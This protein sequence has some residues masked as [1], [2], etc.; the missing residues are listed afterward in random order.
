MYTKGE[1]LLIQETKISEENFTVLLNAA[2]EEKLII[3]TLIKQVLTEESDKLVIISYSY[4]PAILDA[5]IRNLIS[6]SGS[7]KETMMQKIQ[8][9][10]PTQ[11]T[12]EHILDLVKS[13][14][15][16][17]CTVLLIGAERLDELYGQEAIIR[18]TFPEISIQLFTPSQ[19]KFNNTIE[20]LTKVAENLPAHVVKFISVLRIPKAAAESLIQDYMGKEVELVII[21]DPQE[22][23]SSVILNN[24][25][26]MHLNEA[27][28]YIRTQDL[29][30]HQLKMLEFT[31]YI[32]SG[33]KS[34]AL[35]RLMDVYDQADNSLKLM[36]AQLLANEGAEH[37][38]LTILHELKQ[39]D[40]W[41]PGL[42]K[43]LISAS[44]VLEADS[45]E[46][47][48]RELL[49][50]SN[51]P[52]F[53][54]EAA[55]FFNKHENYV[56]S[57]SCWRKLLNNTGDPYYD[58]MARISDIL[59]NPPKKGE[60][61]ESYI[62]GSVSD[63]SNLLDEAHYRLALMWKFIYK[64][65]YKYYYYLDKISESTDFIHAHTVI[66]KKI[67]I[68]KNNGL[69]EKHLKLKPYDKEYDAKKV[70]SI[71][72]NTILQGIPSLFLEDDGY[73]RLQDFIDQSQSL[74]Q[75]ENQVADV[76]QQEIQRW[77]DILNFEAVSHSIDNAPI[78]SHIN[79]QNAVLTIRALRERDGKELA[80]D[81]DSL[82]KGAIILCEDKKDKVHELWVRYE[83]ALLY[84]LLGEFQTTNNHALWLLHFHHRVE[85]PVLRTQALALGLSAWA[86]SQ[87]RLGRIVDGLICTL[88]SIKKGIDLNNFYIIKNG[89]T[90]LFKWL[91]SKKGLSKLKSF[92]NQFMLRILSLES[93][94]NILPHVQASLLS[95]DWQTAYDLLQPHVYIDPENYKPLWAS[96][97]ANYITTCIK[98]QQKE[99]ALKLVY[100]CSKDA[101]QLL[102]PDMKARTLHMWSQILL[103]ESNQLNL[104]ILELVSTLLIDAV[105]ELEKQ[106][107]Q[108]F[109]KPERAA[110]GEQYQ[111]IYRML[112]QVQILIYNLEDSTDEQKRLAEEI[113]FNTL[114][115]VSPRAISEAKL[116]FDDVTDELRQAAV[117]YQK[118]YEELM[119]AESNIEN[120]DFRQ[121]REKF[122]VLQEELC[123]NHPYFKPLSLNNSIDFD[124]IRSQL[125]KNQI[126][127]QYVLCPFGII[128]MLVTGDRKDFGQIPLKPNE[129]ITLMEGLGAELSETVKME[130]SASLEHLC[131]EISEAI[132]GP[133]LK[134]RLDNT[135]ELIICPDMR[136]PSLS[137][138]LIR[139]EDDWVVN[140][141]KSIRNVLDP[142]ELIKTQHATRTYVT[143]RTV[144]SIGAHIRP[145][146][147]PLNSAKDW[148]KKNTDR[149]SLITK[150]LNVQTSGLSQALQEVHPKLFGI[151]AHGIPDPSAQDTILGAAT[152]MGADGPKK[153]VL[154]G[155][156]VTQ[157]MSYPQCTMLITCS[158]GQPSI[159]NLERDA[160]LWS[161]IQEKDINFIACR[162]DVSIEP[163]L[164]ILD[165]IL[166]NKDFKDKALAEL[167]CSAQS[168]LLKSPEWVH[169]AAWAAFE[170]WGK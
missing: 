78:A 124:K 55:N 63:Y 104:A 117:E 112:L 85:D 163:S 41:L 88:V 105:D 147:D 146:Y 27:L 90:L 59:Q 166:T 161:S 8:I 67:N 170:Y 22:D 102:R 6:S 49:R 16:I 81:I 131:S 20:A 14:D 152:I 122:A 96:H 60:D 118:L 71:R 70:S 54:Q 72:L 80:Q 9:I 142:N 111:D 44:R 28:D 35:D 77:L 134:E 98:L 50:I 127:Y 53:L 86:D 129:L 11:R 94:D 2:T 36:F 121:K 133:I 58:M 26:K 3:A 116:Y 12:I 115:K 82:V 157:L 168:N 52:Y 43:A 99:E 113:A 141:I 34:E 15:P 79:P 13:I 84:S 64:S 140:K 156:E 30:E 145:K 167:L 65:E 73:I 153:V 128:Y 106:R 159:Y 18:K 123:R 47:L 83:S 136:I 7:L 33:L 119:I 107:G 5:L 87:F 110:L 114:I 150:D 162:W 42:A 154:H 37:E 21:A 151:I 135:T 62:L 39:N 4:K 23:I 45:R 19:V 130:K 57:A 165:H 95:E 31:A 76:L 38:A 149:L 144:L 103:F 155:D 92:F 40:P 160:G 10:E 148:I 56:D 69:I 158:S 120:D 66:T 138:S 97:L 164:K 125:T 17:Q 68:L 109:H 132:F 101:A 143:D 32:K 75:W 169:P 61:A 24:I 29:P 139:F 48:I 91:S 74:Q 46:K 1:N 126:F 108:L 137:S 51:D 93:P 100:S 25:S 89:V